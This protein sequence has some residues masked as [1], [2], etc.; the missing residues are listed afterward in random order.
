MA[1]SGFM[2]PSDFPKHPWQVLLGDHVDVIAGLLRQVGLPEVPLRGIDEAA[3]LGAAQ[4]RRTP[5][6]PQL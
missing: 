3:L 2:Y 1:R 5:L 6:S 4:A